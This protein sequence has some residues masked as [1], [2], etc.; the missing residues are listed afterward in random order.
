M[1]KNWFHVKYGR[2]LIC[3]FLIQ[4]ILQLIS[5]RNSSISALHD[6]D[7]ANE[8]SVKSNSHDFDSQIVFELMECSRCQLGI[9]LQEN[10]TLTNN[11]MKDYIHVEL[12]NVFTK[13]RM[14]STFFC[15]KNS[16]YERHLHGIQRF[17][18]KI[19]H[20]HKVHTTE[21][22]CFHENI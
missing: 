6:V 19:N 18:E 13:K 12:W 15:R 20:H 14:G 8:I 10:W 4:N 9:M 1:F 7:D 21:K 17:H 16:L 11:S 2:H 5:C 3:T 22:I